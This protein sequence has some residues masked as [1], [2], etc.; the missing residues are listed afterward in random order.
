MAKTFK[1]ILIANRGEIARRVIRTCKKMGIKTVAVYSEADL[2]SLHV[3]EADEA[4]FIGPSPSNQSYLVIDN[5]IDACLQTGA[6]AVHPGY[7]FLSENAKFAEK[8]AAVGVKFI[9][10]EPKA[11]AYMGDKIEAKKHAMNAEV[12]VVPGYQGQI[13]DE[14]E[15]AEIAGKIGYPVMF[16]A[17]AGGGGKGMRI[18]NSKAEVAQ[19][20]VT[21]RN[22]A[23]KSFGD[24]R[25]F[26]EK[27]IT[28]PRHIEIQILGDEHGNVICLGERECSIQRHNQKVIEEAPSAFIDDKTR[29]EMYRQATALAKLVGYSNAGTVEFIMDQEKNF[30]FLEINTRLQVEHPVTEYVTGLDLVEEQIKIALGNKLPLTQKDV[31]LNGWAIESRIYAEDPTRGFLPSTGRITEYMEPKTSKNVRVDSGIYAG[32]EVS[33]FYDAMVAKL[34]TYGKDRAEAVS[35]MQVAL[36]EYVIGGISHNISFLQAIFEHDRFRAG[37]LSTKFIEQEYPK[38]FSGAELTEYKT[39][40]LLSV[41]LYVYVKDAYRA[42]RITG[43]IPEKQR[44]IPERLVVSV[45]EGRFTLNYEPIKDGFE[46][47]FER[48]YFSVTSDFVLGNKLWQGKIDGEVANVYIEHID[49]GYLLT[50][51]GSKAKVTVRSLR[52]AELEKYIPEEDDSWMSKDL[53]A[54]I[55]GGIVEI[56]VKEGQTVTRGQDLIVLEAM[57]MENILYAERDAI[58][59]EIKVKKG[60][61]VSVNQVLI[62][63]KELE[64]EKAA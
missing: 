57:K 6:D 29:A 10:P 11:I 55:S 19:A 4:V 58:V 54:P 31:K 64:E 33:M 63:F 14:K 16:K 38:G 44:R 56:R 25:I 45:D 61:S 20:L 41:G 12:S 1:K 48:E 7:G 59:S 51:M 52:V 13:E 46:I 43:Q 21:T 18:V 35:R 15:A 39:K 26:I 60:D 36:S 34:I 42:S 3:S 32:G 2:N 53:D 47:K 24:D 30:Y 62:K 8:L 17:A 5:I 23:K 49:G 40:V 50:Y 9:G 28:N 27:F 22:E 37:N